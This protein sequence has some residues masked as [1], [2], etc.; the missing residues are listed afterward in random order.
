MWASFQAF[1]W[2]HKT[3]V[4]LTS[5][6]LLFV[7]ETLIFCGANPS[8]LHYLCALF[9]CS[10]AVSVFK[11]YLA[12]SELVPVGNDNNVDGLTSIM[13]YGVS[14]LP[15]KYLGL[16][17]ETSF[18]AK[19]NMGWCY[20]CYWELLLF[21][22]LILCSDDVSGLKINL[23][24]SELVPVGN[25][26][27]V[28]GLASILGYGV[29]Y[30]PLK[31]LGLLLE[32]SFKA[33]SIWDGVIEKIECRLASWKMMHLSKGGRNHLDQE[34]PIQFAY[35]FHVYFS[36]PYWCCQSQREVTTRFLME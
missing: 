35:I 18:K 25:D 14:Y 13:G 31:Y 5:S 3:L 33:K 15:L 30:L 22:C 17:L 12:K 8:Q 4:R 16:L 27:N 26:N 28:D 34:H 1:L 10:E 23:A 7:D 32:T 36:P 21:V 6:H 2:D 11:I 19:S 9:L 29:S 24:K 20:S